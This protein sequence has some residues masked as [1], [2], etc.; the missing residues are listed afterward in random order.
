MSPLSPANPLFS[1]QAGKRMITGLSHMGK[2]SNEDRFLWKRMRGE[3]SNMG[4]KSEK[5][6]RSQN[7][8]FSLSPFHA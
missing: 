3:V 1:T 7:D 8:F 5:G 4:K 6:S 2:K